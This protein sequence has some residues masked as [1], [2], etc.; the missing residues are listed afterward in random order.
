MFFFSP[1]HN[2]LLSSTSRDLCGL[3]HRRRSNGLFPEG[4]DPLFDGLAYTHYHSEVST[5]RL[6]SMQFP[7][8]RGLEI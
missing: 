6:T 5:G 7:R 8:R 1:Q 2:N 3:K 4:D